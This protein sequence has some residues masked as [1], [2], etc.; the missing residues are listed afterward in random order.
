METQNILKIVME[1]GSP[2]APTLLELI[3]VRVIIK[4]VNKNFNNGI[5]G[6]E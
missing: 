4:L 2:F 5:T 1:Q 6:K 3:L